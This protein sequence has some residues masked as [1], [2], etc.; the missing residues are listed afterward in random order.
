MVGAWSLSTSIV[1]AGKDT[2]ATAFADFAAD[3]TL[4]YRVQTPDG[5]TVIDKQGQWILEADGKTLRVTRE[6]LGLATTLELRG[7][8]LVSALSPA[9]VWHR[10]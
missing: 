10:R 3:G 5:T 2:S 7:D 9:V 4:R 8:R 1:V 6:D